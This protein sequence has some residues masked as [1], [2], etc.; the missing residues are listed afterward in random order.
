MSIPKER[1]LSG[2]AAALA[3]SF[4]TA[5]TSPHS[6]QGVNHA[7]GN[8]EITEPAITIDSSETEHGFAST[9]R[10]AQIEANNTAIPQNGKKTSASPPFFPTMEQSLDTIIEGD[11]VPSQADP[12]STKISSPFSE[13]LDKALKNAQKPQKSTDGGTP[14]FMPKHDNNDPEVP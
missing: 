5:C 9:I 8:Q 3:F 11:T 14:P 1:L 12:D 4:L 13:A 10:D 7:N 6:G 2:T